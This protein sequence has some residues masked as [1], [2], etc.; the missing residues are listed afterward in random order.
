MSSSEQRPDLSRLI[1]A[2]LL[3]PGAGAAVA[4]TLADQAE[5]R[6]N[7]AVVADL[8][9]RRAQRAY[10]AEVEA[11]ETRRSLGAVGG[12]PWSRAR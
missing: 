10:E 6:A 1:E 12:S 8:R 4:D 3:T 2:L 7:R 9:A 5:A 11:A